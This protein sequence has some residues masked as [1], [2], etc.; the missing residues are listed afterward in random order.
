MRS[1]TF[2][3]HLSIQ[4]INF[5]HFVRGL[6]LC[7]VLSLTPLVGMATESS[8][9]KKPVFSHT[10]FGGLKLETATRGTVRLPLSNALQQLGVQESLYDFEKDPNLAFAPGKDP[11]IAL[12]EQ[13]K[14]AEGMFTKLVPALKAQGFF[15]GSRFFI[16]S[17]HG[18]IEATIESVQYHKVTLETE[19]IDWNG[20]AVVFNL[21]LKSGIPN[22]WVDDN[23]IR[24]DLCPSL[25]IGDVTSESMVLLSKHVFFQP[26]WK[27]LTGL[28]KSHPKLH[29]ALQRLKPKRDDW[30]Q[31]QDDAVSPISTLQLVDDKTL[32]FYDNQ[33]AEYV[34]A[35]FEGY[36]EGDGA[37]SLVVVLKKKG[38]RYRVVRK[39]INMGT[40]IPTVDLRQDGV[41]DLMCFYPYSEA[42]I[43]ETTPSAKDIDPMFDRP[44]LENSSGV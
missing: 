10:L 16:N 2:M 38:Q 40:C 4:H 39:L 43:F 36:V 15:P 35:T 5:R 22:S 18:R 31:P 8:E 32:I 21:S 6:L 14:Y 23:N 30:Y 25:K 42:G 19:M 17:C 29:R 11:K 9:E 44:L 33:G 27:V 28:K 26:Q 37:N 41:P 12:F 7:L 1:K 13:A 20:G 24:P 3:R 34:L